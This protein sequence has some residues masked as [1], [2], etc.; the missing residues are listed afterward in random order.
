MG[1][2]GTHLRQAAATPADVEGVLDFLWLARWA[3]A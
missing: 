2:A 1:A 3:V